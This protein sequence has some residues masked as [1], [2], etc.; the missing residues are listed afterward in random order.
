[1]ASSEQGAKA[2]DAALAD[3]KKA[4]KMAEALQA[5]QEMLEKE[6]KAARADTAKFR[7]DLRNALS[8]SVLPAPPAGGGGDGSGSADLQSVI[9]QLHQVRCGAVEVVVD[10]TGSRRHA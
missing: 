10:A 8:L 7:S 1:M 2:R 9:T 3:S 6:D 4:T 5:M